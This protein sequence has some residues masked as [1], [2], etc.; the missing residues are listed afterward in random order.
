MSGMIAIRTTLYIQ[1]EYCERHTLRDLIRK[2][3]YENDDEIW[4]LFRA[5]VDG[6]THIHSH[7][8]IHRD[9]KPD[10]VFIDVTNNPK[11]GDFGL[12]TS[13]QYDSMS[14]NQSGNPADSEMTRSIGTTFYVAPELKSEVAGSYNDKVDMYSLGIIFFEM[15]YPLLT[16]MERA[17][18]IGSLRKRNFSFPAIL[19]SP[20]NATKCD[21]IKSL[22]SHRP[23]ERPSSAELLRSGKI[24]FQIQDETIQQAL[25]GLSD[26]SSPY[27]LKMMEAL[28]SF[29]PTREIKDHA[30]DADIQSSASMT[31]PSIAIMQTLVK[32]KLCEIFRRH[33]A[34]EMQRQGVFPRSSY[35]TN[36]HV[37][38]L[39]NPSGTLVQLPYD[40]TL[41]N[42]R[43]IARNT[44]P[45]ERTYAFGQVYRDVRNG[46]APRANGEVDFD[47]VSSASLDPAL[48][49]AEVLKVMDEIVHEIPSLRTAQMCFHL[50]H[51]IILDVIMEFCRISVSQRAAVKEVLSRLNIQ[52]TSWQKLRNELRAP[53]FGIA[54][55]SLDDMAKFDFRDSL[56]K[57]IARI[58]AILG[59]NEYHDRLQPTYAHLQAVVRFLK[60]FGVRSKTYLCPLS[61]YNE[62]FYKGGVLFQC[63]FDTK[64]R[65]VLA[66][67]GRY[68]NLIE[69]HKP[70][71]GHSQFTGC[72]AVGMSLGWDRLVSSMAKL[73]RGQSKSSSFL[74]KAAQIS[75]EVRDQWPI[76]R[77]SVLVASFDSKTLRSAALRVLSELWANNISSEL[78]TDAS[79]LEELTTRYRDEKHSWIVIIKND[80]VFGKAD[81]K[82]K[83]LLTKQ[84]ADVSMENLIPHLRAELR[85][86][87]QREGTVDRARSHRPLNAISGNALDIAGASSDRQP[88][89]Q[90]LLA[91]HKGKKTNRGSVIE[92]AQSRVQEHLASYGSGTAPIAAV[93]TTD[94]LLELLRTSRLSD[95]DSWKKVIQSAPANDRS[96]IHNIQSMLLDFRTEFLDNNG[97]RVAFIFNFRTGWIG[98][99]DL[100]L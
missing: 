32:E 19:E 88:N 54:S 48:K 12:A 44:P 27:Y 61:C 82:V 47:I 13:G 73:H 1:M 50:S 77:C 29:T 64:R 93:E 2:G 15:C 10:N 57:G 33:G 65:E 69:D 14:K 58:Q 92:A 79:S 90:I 99:Y 81:L 91:Q 78:A 97:S 28:F 22:V 5:I 76:R 18:V 11:I 67:G 60:Q 6:L 4:R 17:E 49:E 42:A 7:G 89:V 55:T 38:E 84:D 95:P 35:Y 25:R 21:I 36:E 51:S 94:A 45:A 85:E 68:D 80:L 56:E 59:D 72:H 100:S 40:L 83:S 70:K 63:L 3:L 86:R 26:P 9:L 98:M 71:G 62:K 8:I 66:A 52:D 39:L 16:G 34:I 37:V 20:E 30:W 75:E 87:D 46:G 23:S 41:P 43:A 31:D 24:P 96:Y 53:S 74:K